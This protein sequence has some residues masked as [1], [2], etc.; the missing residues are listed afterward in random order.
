MAEIREP[1]SACFDGCYCSSHR[2]EVHW[3]ARQGP[4]CSSLI[5]LLL[6]QVQASS[7]R[8]FTPASQNLMK[9]ATEHDGNSQ[10][11]SQFDPAWRLSWAERSVLLGRASEWDEWTHHSTT[12]TP[13]GKAWGGA[14]PTIPAHPF[15]PGSPSPQPPVP[16]TIQTL[17]WK[18]FKGVLSW[19]TL[20]ESTK[21]PSNRSPPVRE[22]FSGT[23]TYL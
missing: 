17:K 2:T 20:N 21:D 22:N 7:N 18:W 11:R 1:A 9:P 23:S 3:I 12:L 14:Q 10:G 19:I 15:S 16:Q 13:H 6:A 4:A 5:A 8:P